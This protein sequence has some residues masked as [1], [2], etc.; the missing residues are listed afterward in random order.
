MQKT[1]YYHFKKNWLWLGLNLIFLG[2]MLSC[3][4]KHPAFWVWWEAKTLTILLLLLLALWIY[5]FLMKH[6]MA[7]IDDESIKIDHNKP[8]KWADVAF[9]E[10]RIV[11]CCGSKRRVIVL[12]PKEDLKY[13]YNFLQKHNGEFTPFSIPLYGILDPEDEV[14]LTKIVALKTG[15]KRL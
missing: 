3:C 9:A 2:G 6:K 12:I 10:E 4:F 14:E 15:L 1:F 8:L 5:L 7:V 11:R 13:D